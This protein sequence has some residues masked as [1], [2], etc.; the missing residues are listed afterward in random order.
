MK[1]N[2]RQVKAEIKMKIE[3]F[4]LQIACSMHLRFSVLQIREFNKFD[5]E[6]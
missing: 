4:S 3:I 5:I 2:L 6:N 1:Q